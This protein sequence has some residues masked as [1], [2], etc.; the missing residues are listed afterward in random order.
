MGFAQDSHGSHLGETRVDG[1][2]ADA[3][4]EGVPEQAS[5][6]AVE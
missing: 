2:E 5:G 3:D 1:S 4:N 6:A